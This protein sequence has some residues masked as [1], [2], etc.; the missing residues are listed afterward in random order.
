MF[1]PTILIDFDKTI[2]PVHGFY[3]PPSNDVIAAIKKLQSKY[4]ISIYSTRCNPE[5]SNGEGVEQIT[6]YMTEH[7]VPFDSICS[8]KPVFA[9]LIDDRSFNPNHVSWDKIVEDLLDRVT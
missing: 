4:D 6:A 1:K 8:R 3:A 9:A 5:F 7:G 2:S